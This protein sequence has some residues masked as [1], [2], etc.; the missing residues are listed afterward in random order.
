MQSRPNQA[1]RRL[2]SQRIARVAVTNEVT[3][4]RTRA[5]QRYI[6]NLTLLIDASSGGFSVD[7]LK[8]TPSE[9]ADVVDRRA[10]NHA[11]MQIEAAE[12]LAAIRARRGQ[13]VQS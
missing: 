8:L 1:A 3:L 2:A 12:Q 13:M 9:L 10:V 7:L 6:G 11:L 4:R 5:S